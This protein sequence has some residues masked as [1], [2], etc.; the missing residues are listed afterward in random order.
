MKRSQVSSVY[1][2]HMKSIGWKSIEGLLG[3]KRPFLI[4]GKR[5]GSEDLKKENEGKRRKRTLTDPVHDAEDGVNAIGR[6]QKHDEKVMS[7]DPKT[8]VDPGAVMI[9]TGAAFVTDFAV[10]CSDGLAM[11][12]S[13]LVR[14]GFS[15]CNEEIKEKATNETSGAK[16]FG[17]ETL[18]YHR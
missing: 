15:G 3:S 12:R 4:E 7:T 8:V 11:L 9:E 14:H 17:V 5:I 13:L 2:C 1:M 16:V 10:L 18:R 6:H